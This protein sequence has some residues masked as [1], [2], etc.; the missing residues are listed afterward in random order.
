M[1]IENIVS[2]FDDIT[3]G[4]VNLY[5]THFVDLEWEARKLWNISNPDIYLNDYYIT[6][7]DIAGNNILKDSLIGRTA[8]KGSDDAQKED[9]TFT[10]DLPNHVVALDPQVIRTFMIRFQPFIDGK[11]GD[12]FLQS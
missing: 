4:D 5:T 9:K 2:K 10:P 11:N 3:V 8:W 7:L 6:E 1:R 12:K